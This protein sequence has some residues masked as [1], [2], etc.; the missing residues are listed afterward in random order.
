MEI[1]N[2]KNGQIVKI[3][4]DVE[5]LYKVLKIEGSKAT[6]SK[7]NMSDEHLIANIANLIFISN[8]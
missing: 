3:D 7:Q 8:S 1:K 4:N 2:C 5:T 6:L